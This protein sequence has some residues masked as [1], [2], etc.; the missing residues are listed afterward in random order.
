VKICIAGWYLDSNLYDKI[1]DLSG[2]SIVSHRSDY[3]RLIK[4]IDGTKIGAYP[5]K[6]IGLEFHCYCFYLE[7]IWD[8]KSDVLFMHDDVDIT[9]ISVFD[10]IGSLQVDQAYIFTT[11]D[12]ERHNGGKHGRCIYMSAALLDYVKSIGGIWYDKNNYGYT[13]NGE[14]RPE[15]GMDYNAGINHF[16]KT[17]GKIRDNKSLSFNVVNR[18]FIDKIKIAKRG[19]F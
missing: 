17:M 19:K 8:E 13:G 7:N 14:K 16:H 6:N 12:D 4:I 9:D 11:S 15:P 18:V 5:I 3:T 2:V 1:K 10:D